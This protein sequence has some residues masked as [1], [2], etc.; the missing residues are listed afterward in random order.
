V[1]GDDQAHVDA[2]DAAEAAAG[3]A[4]AVAELNENSAGCGS[5]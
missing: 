2:D 5:A 1:V 4:G 3:V